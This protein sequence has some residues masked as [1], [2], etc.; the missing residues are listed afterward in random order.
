MQL[1]VFHLVARR[2][3]LCT[4]SKRDADKPLNLAYSSRAG[5][6]ASASISST[7]LFAVPARLVYV[8]PGRF[9]NQSGY[10]RFVKRLDVLSDVV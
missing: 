1:K 7:K 8:A 5:T 6:T 10:Y 3:P 9:K 2:S 4:L